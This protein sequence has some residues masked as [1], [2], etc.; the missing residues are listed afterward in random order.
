M[1]HL[2]L[3]VIT[4]FLCSLCKMVHGK[5]IRTCLF[6]TQWTLFKNHF[7]LCATFAKTWKTDKNWHDFHDD[8]HD[9]NSG[10][11]KSISIGRAVSENGSDLLATLIEMSKYGQG[12]NSDRRRITENW[13]PGVLCAH[14]AYYAHLNTPYG[15]SWPKHILLLSDNCEV[16]V[17]IFISTSCSISFLFIG[18][19]RIMFTIMIM[20]G[21]I[22]K[23]LI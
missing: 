2:Y 5:L 4:I 21:M 22:L 3:C 7:N 1:A 17:W 14:C 13:Q 20:L 19:L 12:S 16:F 6:L 10:K 9:D 8:F 23:I 11:V 15:S 18:I